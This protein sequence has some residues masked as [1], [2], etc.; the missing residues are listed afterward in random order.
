MVELIFII[1]IICV[2]CLLAMYMYYCSENSVGMF[3]NPEY[4]KRIRRLEKE[5]EKLKTGDNL[6]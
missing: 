2:T 1:L 4:E 3:T 5:M 6:K